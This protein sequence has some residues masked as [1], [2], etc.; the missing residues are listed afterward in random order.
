MQ[1]MPQTWA[2]LRSRYGVGANPFDPHD[3]IFAGAAYLHE[4][5]DRY[6][7]TG[8]LAGYN[9]GPGRY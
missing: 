8:L 6:G 9:A 2:G 3:N 7:A 5:H 4:L 1:I